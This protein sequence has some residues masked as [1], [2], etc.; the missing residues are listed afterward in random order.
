[1]KREG[2]PFTFQ[3]QL[4]GKGPSLSVSIQKSL[5]R[6]PVPESVWKEFILSEIINDRGIALDR[7]LVAQAMIID[8]STRAALMEELKKSTGLENPNSVQQMKQ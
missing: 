7:D 6:F 8:A 3:R 5:S 4:K 1:M 2:R